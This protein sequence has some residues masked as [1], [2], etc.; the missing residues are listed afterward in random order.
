[1]PKGKVGKEYLV[2]AREDVTAWPEA[3]VLTNIKSETIAKFINEEIITQYRCVE[4]IVVDGG[5]ENKQA[6]EELCAKMNIKHHV[7]TPYHPQ[8]NGMIE[9]GHKTFVHA[10]AILC[11]EKPHEWPEHLHSVL[12]ADRVTIR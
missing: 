12:W 10:L 4:R 2:V 11:E 8:A 9:R 5:S 7:I 3:R 1:M 6:V